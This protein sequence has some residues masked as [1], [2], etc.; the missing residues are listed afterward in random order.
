MA[1]SSYIVK[2]LAAQIVRLNRID[3]S[4]SRIYLFDNKTEVC[5]DD[6]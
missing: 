5:V 3:V 6:C 1:I 2:A 4:L